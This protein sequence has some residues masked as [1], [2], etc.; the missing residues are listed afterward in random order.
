[1]VAAGGVVFFGLLDRVVY[2]NLISDDFSRSFLATAVRADFSTVHVLNFALD[3]FFVTWLLVA[4]RESGIRIFALLSQ[5]IWWVFTRPA[6]VFLGQHSLHVF[7]FHLVVV[8]AVSIA[9]DAG[10][11]GEILGTILLLLGAL[12]LYLPAWLHARSLQIE[13]RAR[14]V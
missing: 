1:V 6:L 8:Y 7:S 9:F 4:G 13:R 5:A 14:Q 10:P 3:L 11:P 2:W 12:S